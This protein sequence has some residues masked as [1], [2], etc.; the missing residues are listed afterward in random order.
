[1]EER[2]PDSRRLSIELET[3]MPIYSLTSPS[4]CISHLI[5]LFFYSSE[6]CWLERFIQRVY[7]YVVGFG[8][9]LFVGSLFGSRFQVLCFEYLVP[10]VRW[11]IYAMTW[12]W[13]MLLYILT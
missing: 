2:G 7:R 6:S 13:N 1:M 3:Y 10:L 9:I 11:G 4:L 5:F 12:E 8:V